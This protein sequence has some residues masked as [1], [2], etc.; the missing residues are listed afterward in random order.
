MSAGVV[1]LALQPKRDILKQAII[2]NN[3]DN[4]EETKEAM[5]EGK[6]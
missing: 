6:I 2:E 4:I 5:M 3:L 1:E